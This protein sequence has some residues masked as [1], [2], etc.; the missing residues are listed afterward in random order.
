M[1]LRSPKNTLSL[2]RTML[3]LRVKEAESLQKLTTM[4]QSQNKWDKVSSLI[5]Q[6]VQREE[7]IKPILN[8]KNYLHLECDEQ[9]GIESIVVWVP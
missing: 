3:L 7:S 6:K 2:L 8:K 9:S 1:L 5:L 4:G